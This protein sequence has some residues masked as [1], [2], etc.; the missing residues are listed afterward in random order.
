MKLGLEERVFII[1]GGSRGI[2]LG[3]AHTLL[4]EGARVAL[5]A[6]GRA[7]LERATS[8]LADVYGRDHVIGRAGDLADEAMTRKLLNYVRGE[9]GTPAG[10]VLNAGNGSGSSSRELG[11]SEWQRLFAANLWPSVVLAEHL[12]PDLAAAGSGSLVFIS[13]IAS[14]KAV[15]APLAYGAAKA[16]LEYYVRGL[17]RR[18]GSDQVRVNAIAPGNVLS[19]GGVWDSKL[20]EDESSWQ[21]YLESEVPLQRLGTV[22]EIAAPAAFLLSDRASFITGE[23]LLVDGGQVSV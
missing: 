19:P 12:L 9:W 17:A 13:S 23:V 8:R 7:E 14:R 1:G 22:D 16:A 5:V 2:G 6:R 11:L 18:S 3:V 15:G 4:E 10:A 20:A 21:A